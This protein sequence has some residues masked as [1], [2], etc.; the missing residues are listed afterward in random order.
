MKKGSSTSEAE[1]AVIP[2]GAAGRGSTI[3]V[4]F[5]STK[6]IYPVIRCH[7]NAMVAD[8][9]RWEQ[10]A[11]FLLDS[12]PGVRKWVKNDRLGFYIPYRSRG[13]PAKYLPDF[14][15]VTDTKQN[16]IV[17]IKGQMTDNADVKAKAA[18]RWTAAVTRLGIYG[19]W[20]YLLVTDPGRLGMM[21]NGHTSAAWDQGEFQLG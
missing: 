12:H 2:Q 14:I 3:Y 8:T 4:D 16:I 6:P 5:H 10:S 19:T 21:L 9:R 7:L 18:Q 13:I 11:A 20:H 17:E 1:L 15:V